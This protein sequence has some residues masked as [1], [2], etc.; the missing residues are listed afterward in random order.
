VG[1][2]GVLDGQ[3]VKVELAPDR[4]ELGLVRLVQADPDKGV[5]GVAGLVRLVE[6]DFARPPLTV[7]V[8]RAVDDHG[9][10]VP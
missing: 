2:D 9:G 8:D 10:I 4:L 1:V 5:V 7:L 6:S 3:L